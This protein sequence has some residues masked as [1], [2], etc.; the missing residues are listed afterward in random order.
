MSNYTTDLEGEIDSLRARLSE[1]E[2]ERDRLELR[3]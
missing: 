3:W 2:A 1:V